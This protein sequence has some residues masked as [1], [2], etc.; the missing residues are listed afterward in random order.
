MSTDK[1]IF[2]TL[3]K[4]FEESSFDELEIEIDDL[5]IHLVREGSGRTTQSA[6]DTQSPSPAETAASPTP[7]TPA[8]P[9]EGLAAIRAPLSGT[10][11][12]APSPT[13]PPFLELGSRVEIDDTIGII[14][15]MK[16]FNTVKADISGIVTSI[17]KENASEVQEGET[18]V[19]IQP[20]G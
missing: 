1:E 15:V 3:L 13:E 4:E 14:E 16:L 6:V 18:L 12:H 5:R 20:D 11:Y 2:D 8:A 17:V 19:Y 7:A 9:Q 10:F